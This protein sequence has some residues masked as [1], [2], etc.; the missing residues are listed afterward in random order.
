M[1]ED[2]TAQRVLAIRKIQRSLPGRSRLYASLRFL[3]IPPTFLDVIARHLPTQGVVLD[4]GCG[5]GL[6]TL[7]FAIR[8]PEC[9]FIGLDSS[10][11]RID[12]A[13]SAAAAL[14]ISNVKFVCEDIGAYQPSNRLTAVYCVDLIHHLPPPIGNDIVRKAFAWL[15]PGGRLIVKE[16]DTR[17]LVKMYFTYVLDLL[18]SRERPYYRNQMEWRA[19]LMQTGFVSLMQRSLVNSL[20][21]PHIL[22]V[23][24]K[25]GLPIPTGHQVTAQ[26]ASRDDTGSVG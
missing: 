2:S 5:F 1:K 26:R 21:Y 12:S 13:R 15:D 4:A 18:V 19:L 16:I 11:R 14:R 22:L 17:P 8:C 25:P 7:Y 20:P 10:S 6:F 3:I 24:T 23:G 9:R